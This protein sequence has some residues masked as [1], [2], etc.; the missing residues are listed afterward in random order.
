MGIA[1]FIKDMVGFL[2]LFLV[3][4]AVLV[5]GL[6]RLMWQAS[7]ELPPGTTTLMLGDSH[8]ECAVN[9]SLLPGTFN[10][11]QAGDAFLYSH[12][13]LRALIDRN[14][15]LDTVWLSYNF[16]CLNGQLDVLTRSEK[17][18]KSKLP[19]GGFLL[20]MEDLK[21]YAGQYAFYSVIIRTPYIR[22]QFI[23]KS[24]VRPTTLDDLRLGGYLHMERDKLASD[25]AKRDSTRTAGL[26]PQ[27]FGEAMDQI[28][29][30]ERTVEL[31]RK[32]G[33]TCILL[34][35]PV[36][37]IVTHDADTTAYYA[38]QEDHLEGTVLW[39]HSAWP[40]PDSA[41]ADA[42]HLNHK[43]AAIYTE[44]LRKLRSMNWPSTDRYGLPL[45]D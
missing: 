45:L 37:P 40:L 11:A 14:P 38:F 21:V 12:A 31:C 10:L 32:K 42:T 44:R 34:N 22:R 26:P 28:N 8:I 41:Y 5:L 9:D 27:R 3:L 25:L 43:G 29:Y 20:D 18:C 33:L 19:F 7:L 24:L 16:Q 30:L 13:K 15:Q 1:R 17:Y 36:H 6:R 2:F 4:C 23:K 39:D 35:T